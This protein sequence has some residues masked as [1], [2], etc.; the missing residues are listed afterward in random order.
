MLGWGTRGTIA[1]FSSCK[2]CKAISVYPFH[3]VFLDTCIVRYLASFPSYF[4]EN[5]ADEHEIERIRA[6]PNPSLQDDIFVLKALPD[7]FQRGFP[8]EIVVTSD[9]IAELP[10][11]ARTYG[12]ELLN[13]CREMKFLNE[14]VPRNFFTSIADILDSSDRRLYLQAAALGCDTFLTTDYKTIVSRRD[15]LPRHF[16]RVLTPSE[17]WQEMRPWAGLAG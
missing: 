16:A 11:A 5:G 10:P 14:Y 13:W 3:S 6:I 7:L 2:E 12:D 8:H 15:R 17:W 9:V 4:Y 1:L